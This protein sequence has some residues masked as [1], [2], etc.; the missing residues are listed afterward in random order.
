MLPGLRDAGKTGRRMLG[1]VLEDGNQP[2]MPDG[3]IRYHEQDAQSPGLSPYP[4]HLCID[5]PQISLD[6]L[7]SPAKG[8]YWLSGDRM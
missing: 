6:P 2:V 4:L 3:A 7:T 1:G 8:A 5:I